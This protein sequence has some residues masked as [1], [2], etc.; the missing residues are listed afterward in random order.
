M[1][2]ILEYKIKTIPCFCILS[3]A[4]RIIFSRKG[5]FE[6]ILG[7]FW[8]LKKNIIGIFGSNFKTISG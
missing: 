8:L 1:Y 3:N 2:A 6:E 5:I 4:K 7:K